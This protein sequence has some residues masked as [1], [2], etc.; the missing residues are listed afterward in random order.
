[1]RRWVYNLISVNGQENQSRDYYDLFM[2]ITILLSLLPLTF[3]V[4]PTYA[5]W[6]DGLAS[7][8]FLLDYGLRLLTADYALGKGRLSFVLYPF[9]FLALIDL[10]SILPTLQWVNG[11]F[12]L[13]RL[14]RLVGSLRVFK[15][16][17]YSKNIR[18]ITNVLKRQREPLSL[19]AFFALAYIFVSA[20]II[21]NIEA[22]TFDNFFD[23]L[24]WATT[25]LT[26]IGYGDI[27]AST[28]LGKLL[29]MLSAFFGIAIVALPAGIITAGYMEEVN[30]RKGQ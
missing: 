3:K 9:T 6:L 2:V 25:T 21:F 10:I 30:R 17:R 24:Y 23:A 27:Y 29:T 22:D 20:L 11:S 26:T 28:D 1:M 13:F 7:L 14:F 19:V 4:M 8:I 15:I 16:F 5:I 12:R 18:L